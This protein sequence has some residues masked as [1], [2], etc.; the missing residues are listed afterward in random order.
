MEKVKPMLAEDLDHFERRPPWGSEAWVMEAKYDGI[1]QL[2]SNEDGAIRYYAR[3]GNEHT[4]R[5]PWLGELTLPSNTLLDG[6]LLV[7]KSLSSDAMALVNR[8]QL[9]YVVFDVLKLDGHDF[10]REPWSVRRQALELDLFAGADRVSLS[11]AFKP[12]EAVADQLVKEGYEGVVLKRKDS[13][14][15]E[16]RRSWDWLKR[17]AAYEVDAVITDCNSPP[18]KGSLGDSNGWVVLSYGFY[19]DGQLVRCGSVGSSEPREVQQLKVGKVAVIKCNGINTENGALR[20]PRILRF[21]TDKA[22]EECELAW[23]A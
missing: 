9:V 15:D 23:A 7:P 5:Y 3:S 16:G 18:T 12:D 10:R 13:L 8:D 4:G 22:A 21:R 20:H 14:Y 2:W 6:E 19:R 11:L 1:R 17:K